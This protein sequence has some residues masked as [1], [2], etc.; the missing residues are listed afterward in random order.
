MKSKGLSTEPWETSHLRVD[1]LALK[2]LLDTYC[3]L[4]NG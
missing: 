3:F 2:S 1:V 4:L